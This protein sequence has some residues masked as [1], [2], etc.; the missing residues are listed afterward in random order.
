MP[1]G[2]RSEFP[3]DFE[4]T[5]RTFPQRNRLIAGLSDVLFLP[6]AREKSGSLITADFALK[7]NKPVYVVPNQLFS[8]NGVGSNQLISR[9][10]VRM[11]TD[12][13]QIFRYF[14]PKKLLKEQKQ[15]ILTKQEL[16]IL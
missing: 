11:L 16:E 12:F 3:L 6:E 10:Q 2:S 7:M 14:G 15:T 13:Q 1:V 8:K 9:G 4:P 5:N